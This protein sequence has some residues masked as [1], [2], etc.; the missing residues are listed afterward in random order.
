MNYNEFR[1]KFGNLPLIRGSY[2]RLAGGYDHAMGIQLAR[3]HNKRLVLQLRKGLYILNENDRRVTPSRMF[4]AGEI[5]NPSY[6][7]LE[8]ALSFYGLIPERAA[9]V[10]CVTTRKTA[11]FQNDF[12]TFTY[13]H[14]KMNCFNGFTEQKDENGLS[15]FIATP[16]K[17][18]A[19]FIY[20]HQNTFAGDYRKALAESMRLQNTAG[21]NKN[22]IRK[23]AEAFGSKKTS[24]IASVLLSS[25]ELR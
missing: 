25:K 5:Y 12:G 7:S 8:Y 6:V 22:K 17:A 10:T 19:D 24:Q 4:M 2:I 13:Q 16:E 3:W 20:L 21:L 14:V 1:T 18:V 23:Y 11:R 15:F 9:D